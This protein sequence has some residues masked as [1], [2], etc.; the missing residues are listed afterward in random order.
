MVRPV[1]RYQRWEW[2]T[3]DLSEVDEMLVPPPLEIFLMLL[4]SHRIDKSLFL[5]L[6]YHSFF[7]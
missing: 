3:W 2:A 5:D 1:P 7:E 6:A 4:M